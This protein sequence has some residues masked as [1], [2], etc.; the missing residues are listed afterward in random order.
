MVTTAA[1]HDDRA[2][3]TGAGPAGAGRRT[4]PP[5]LT[6][7]SLVGLAFAAVG[8]FLGATPLHDNSL[9]THIATGRLL[10]HGGLG[11]LWNGMADPYTRFGAGRSWVVQSWLP[12][13][14]YALVERGVGAGGIRVLMAALTGVLAWLLWRLSAPAVT[15]L[16][17]IALVGAALVVGS[18]AWSQRPFLVGLV[19]LAVV[20]L[21]ADGRVDPRWLVPA[22]WVWVNSHG[23]FPFAVVALVAL[24]VGAR[25]DG[26]PVGAELRALGW[27]VAGI[28]AGGVA[29]PV[30]PK[31]LVFPVTMLRRHD[32]LTRVV[33]W[34]SPSFDETWTRAFLV[35]VLAV[36]LGVARRPSYRAAVPA[37]VFVAAALLAQRNL[38][39]ALV[40][41]VPA[42]ATGLAG[43]GSV[44]GD[45]QGGLLR[46]AAV[47]VAAGAA[48][49]VAG[50][51][52]GADAFALDAYP[53]AAT[54]WLD[55]HG[56][57]GPQTVLA[58]PDY[59]GNYLELREGTRVPVFVDDRYELHDATLASQTAGLVRGVPSWDDI[60]RDRGAD[61]VLWE[62]STP[63]G[64]LLEADN[65]AWRV[66][67][68]DDRWLVACRP[69][70]A[71]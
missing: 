8:A 69:D 60:L 71:C 53:V 51:V 35:V 33:E 14:A 2:D 7:A 61:V 66:A 29:S 31:L 55:Q 63:L 56:L 42:A 59:V 13:Y 4:R 49:S 17:R 52:A 43:L 44:R 23:S 46:V 67:Y 16:P 5:R 62:R 47:V 11:Q 70:V 32:A 38:A 22:M 26:R 3:P 34:R 39:P 18:T 54:T 41:L 25:L 45:E 50:A 37:V 15:L 36:V 64:S 28:V 21:A 24:A 30:G 57:L 58:H 19:L 10:V 20:L 40:V 68:R 12:S 48:A 9:F 1:R 27:C 6:L 65:T